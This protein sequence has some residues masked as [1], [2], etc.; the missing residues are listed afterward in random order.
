MA[1]ATGV[2]RTQAV[3]EPFAQMEGACFGCHN[4]RDHG[5]GWKGPL[6]FPGIDSR[7]NEFGLRADLFRVG[8]DVWSPAGEEESARQIADSVQAALL[9]VGSAE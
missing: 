8:M 5:L 4:I 9:L 3:F 7:L 6:V 2:D 1:A